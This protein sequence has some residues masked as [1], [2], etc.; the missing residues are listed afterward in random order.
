MSID[1][2]D[3][4]IRFNGYGS[5]ILSIYFDH[6]FGIFTSYFIKSLIF[7]ILHILMNSSY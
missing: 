1:L 4:F 5:T 2:I 6:K 7:K 3:L